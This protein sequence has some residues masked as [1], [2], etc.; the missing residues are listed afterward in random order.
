MQ[1]GR[2]MF[3]NADGTARFWT[4]TLTRLPM[5]FPGY[6]EVEIIRRPRSSIS[7][8]P[9]P[10]AAAPVPE[11]G[12]EPALVEQLTAAILDWRQAAPGP[13][14]FDQYYAAQVPS[15]RARHASF[16]QIEELL[17][18][19][20]VTPDLFYGTWVR[21][22]AGQLVRTPGLKD[23]LTLYGS[24]SQFDINMTSPP[25]LLSLGIPPDVVAQIVARRTV[26]PFLRQEELGPTMPAA[27]PGAGGCAGRRVEFS[28]SGRRPRCRAMRC[29]GRWRR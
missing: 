25:V 21:N 15:F 16:E 29:A 27:G 14:A 6:A 2:N 24:N 5:R 11:H 22:P 10:G 12:A 7:T 19:R 18:V 1:W 26:R 28:R 23:C 13:T 17:L 9:T 8:P 4:Y 20:G 3:P